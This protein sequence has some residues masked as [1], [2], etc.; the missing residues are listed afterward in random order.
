MKVVLDAGALMAIDRNDRRVLGLIR[1]ARRE[2]AVLTTCSPVVGQV[3][4][5]GAQ[6]ANLARVLPMI[7]VRDV[8]LDDSKDG[9][10]LLRSTKRNDIVDALLSL[11]VSQGDQLFTS[12]PKD[13][14]E[15]LGARRVQATVVKV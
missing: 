7:D 3:W 10:E 14:N 11:L 2:G 4:R 8:D 1:V 12:D 9:G 6:Q 15:L 5:D 13:L